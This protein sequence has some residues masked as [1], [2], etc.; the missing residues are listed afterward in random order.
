MRTRF[1]VSTSVALATVMSWAMPR[2]AAAC[3]EA[4]EPDPGPAL[5]D[6]GPALA[7]FVVVALCGIGRLAFRRPT[8]V[9]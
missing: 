3:P 4:Y 2:N 9:P 8:I 6:F 7:V 1:I 5:E